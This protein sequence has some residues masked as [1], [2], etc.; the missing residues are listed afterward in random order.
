MNHFKDSVKQRMKERTTW[1]SAT[2]W[3]N[4]N[5]LVFNKACLNLRC[6]WGRAEGWSAVVQSVSL[7]LPSPS[8]QLTR[9]C[10][11]FLHLPRSIRS[12]WEE[13]Q[14]WFTVAFTDSSCR[15]V[16]VNSNSNSKFWTRTGSQFPTVIARET[17][18]QRES[19]S[20]AGAKPRMHFCH[21]I[22]W[23][24]HFNSWAERN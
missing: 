8:H 1:H 14:Q 4:E 24:K 13:K 23:K 10:I 21:I 22:W 19:Y 20:S 6:W 12:V 17:V 2:T 16:V 5:L 3:A 9:S 11:L 18:R 15:T 7:S